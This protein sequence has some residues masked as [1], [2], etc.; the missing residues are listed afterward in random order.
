MFG[1]LLR[2][3]PTASNYLLL[4]ITGSC[5]LRELGL[6][7]KPGTE[8]RAG[9]NTNNIKMQSEIKYLELRLDLQT[10]E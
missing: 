8:I 3:L 6:S 2:L 4:I 1:I 5:Q 9:G 10:E 7:R